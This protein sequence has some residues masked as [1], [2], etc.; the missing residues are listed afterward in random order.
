[1][2]LQ[3]LVA[4][5]QRRLAVAQRDD[6]AD[7]HAALRAVL[8]GKACFVAVEQMQTLAHIFQAD[9]AVV[10]AGELL[11]AGQTLFLLR[12]QTAA[13][14]LDGQME[15]VLADIGVDD[16]LRILVLVPCLSAFSTMGWT[17]IVGIMALRAAS[18]AENVTL[19]RSPWM[20]R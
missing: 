5:M 6:D 13:A 14:V 7:D 18:R 19:S 8:D 10:R 11:T 17:I 20:K 2:L 3:I 15:L 12:R 4:K 9:T 1:M 16:D